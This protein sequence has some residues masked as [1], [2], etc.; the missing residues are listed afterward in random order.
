MSNILVDLVEALNEAKPFVY[1]ARKKAKMHEQDQ[2]DAEL[3]FDKHSELLA[4]VNRKK[5][6]PTQ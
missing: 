1:R 6:D 3:W 4:V 5:V 2:I